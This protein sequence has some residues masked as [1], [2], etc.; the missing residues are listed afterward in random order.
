[1][2]SRQPLD[3]GRLAAADLGVDLRDVEDVDVARVDRA[4][5]SSDAAPALVV[6]AGDDLRR[7]GG[8][9]GDALEDVLRRVRRE[10]GDQLVVDRQV[11]GQDEEV[12]D[13]LAPDAGR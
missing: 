5:S 13:A 4:A 2:Y 7:I 12:A 1:M 9:L 8:E 6:V 11:R 10:V 3:A